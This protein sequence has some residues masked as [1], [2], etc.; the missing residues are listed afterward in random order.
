M[1]RADR[2]RQIKDDE[3][4]LKAGIDPDSGDPEPTAAM[5]RQL[6]ALLE[7]AKQAKNIDPAVKFLHSKADA[8]LKRGSGV[9]LACKKGCAHC[10]HAWVS[11]TIPEALFVA[12]LIRKTRAHELEESV[13]RSHVLTSAYD[14]TARQR[15]P[16]PCAMLKDDLCSVYESRPLVCRFAASASALACLRSLRQLTGETIPTPVRHLRGRGVYNVAT[17][18]ALRHAGLPHHFYEF[19]AA[20]ARALERS[21]AE[22]AW[23]GGKD[24][25]LDVKRDPNDIWSVQST[26][27]VYQRA[28]GQT[29]TGPAFATS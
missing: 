8:T 24:V 7:S 9:E 23:L 29:G 15:H 22:A 10:C 28:F 19:N 18:I 17:V 11:L 21:D 14:F 16:T 26:R 4:R 1:N 13:S 6:Y 2:R 12:K 3:Q 27:F 5:A 25:F 20:L